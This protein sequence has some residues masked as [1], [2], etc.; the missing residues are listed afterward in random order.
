MRRSGL[1]EPVSSGV[2]LVSGGPDSAC[3]AAGAGP[4]D[5][6]GERPRAARQLRAPGHRRPRRAGRTRP[7]LAAAGRPPH[8]AADVASGKPPGR[9]PGLPLLGRR[10]APRPRR[11]RLDRHRPQPDRPR[12]DDGLP[13][14]RLAGRPKPPL[15]AARRAGGWSARCSTWSARSCARLATAAGLPFADDE[16]NLDPAF[17]RNR[18]RSEILPVLRD[19]SDAAERNI[20]ETQAELARGGPPARTGRPRGARG[21]GSGR[22]RGRDPGGG[23]GGLR[24]GAPAPGPARPRGASHGPRGAARARAARPRSCAWR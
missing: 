18:I 21:R 2:V 11:R 12:G 9:R 6:A 19:L 8:R 10:A 7:L 5:R 14:R 17:A 23:A 3:A 16:T 15:P 13:P 20:A 4:G 24:A 22:R 1:I